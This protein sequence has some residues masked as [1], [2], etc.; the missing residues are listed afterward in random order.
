LLTYEVFDRNAEKYDE[1]Y[2]RHPE[3]FKCE[4]LVLRS[5]KLNGE[6]LALGVGTG[7]LDVEAGVKLGIDP[8]LNMLKLARKRGV[9]PV[10]SMGETV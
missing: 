7:I 8:S 10:L 1:W 2:L 4:S 5:L 6:G 3:I 9:E